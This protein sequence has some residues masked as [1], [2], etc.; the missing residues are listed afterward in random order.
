MP[1]MLCESLGKASNISPISIRPAAILNMVQ[2]GNFAILPV[3]HCDSVLIE[4]ETMQL[5]AEFRKMNRHV[6]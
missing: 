4:W 5:A 2:P 3:V 1:S 6:F